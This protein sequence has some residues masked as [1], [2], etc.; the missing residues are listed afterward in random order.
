MIYSCVVIEEDKENAEILAGYIT[1][2]PYLDLA[3][4]HYPPYE[5]LEE[6]YADI[7]FINISN[8]LIQHT[9]FLKDL[10]LN[11][12]FV[13][14]TGHTSELA[15]KA[16]DLDA[17]DYLI[18]PIP[19]SRFNETINKC[20]KE[21]LRSEREDVSIEDYFFIKDADDQ[22]NFVKIYYRDVSIVEGFGNYLKI[23]TAAGAMFK[24]KL[25]M[26]RISYALMKMDNFLRIHRSFIISKKHI[27]NVSRTG[28]K[29]QQHK[30]R[31]PFGKSYGTALTDFIQ[32]KSFT[33]ISLGTSRE[34]E[35]T[36]GGRPLFSL[37]VAAVNLISGFSVS[38]ACLNAI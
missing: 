17:R 16:F 27:E 22:N 18:K 7:T 37:L 20:R 14:L 10:K 15:L 5:N 19:H 2:N 6:A 31:I 32:G 9:S 33:K 3:G 38:L 8:N 23:Y 12:R 4:I 24:V 13:V 35:K 28:V 26:M 25:S 30:L 34:E 1:G 21:L 29:M 11:S 36:K